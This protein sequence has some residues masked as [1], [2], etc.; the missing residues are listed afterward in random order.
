MCQ[1]GMC[2]L[3]RKLPNLQFNYQHN[4]DQDVESVVGC[5]IIPRDTEFL[6][7]ILVW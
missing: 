3:D 6:V 5:N 1:R 4:T 7:Q 2:W